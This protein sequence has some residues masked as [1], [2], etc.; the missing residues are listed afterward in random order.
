MRATIQYIE[1]E[2]RDL[3][4]KTE[5]R[6]FTR[7]MLEH[8]CGLNYTQQVLLND[9]LLEDSFKITIG[10]M[11]KRL[12]DHEPIQYIMGEIEFAG[13]KLMVAPPVLIPRPETEELVQW[14]A[15][16]ELPNAP[17]L[18]DVGT[19]S[20]CIA[21]ALKYRIP[22]ASVSALDFMEQAIEVA[23]Q[24]AELNKLEV[25]FFKTDIMNWETKAWRK[26]DAI[27]SNPPY[28]RESEKE[29]MSANVLNYE[30][31]KA[32]FVPDNDPLIFYRRITEFAN[33]W[34]KENGWLFFEINESLGNEMI[35]LVK[36][37]GFKSVEIKKDLFGKDRMLRCRK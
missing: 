37:F 17:A 28:V 35:E 36:G 18:L 10:E 23:H 21:L 25:E 29:N 1:Q 6:A 14:I 26:L 3:Y 24:N 33:R 7:L 15:E 27:I 22:D 13:L 16:T 9:Q 30:S 11:V 5:I 32:L 4:P 34:L 19:G 8:V 12:K 20:G 31:E 2:L